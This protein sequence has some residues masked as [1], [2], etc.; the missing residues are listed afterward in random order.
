[1]TFSVL[2]LLAVLYE[3]N[4]YTVVHHLTASFTYGDDKGNGSQAR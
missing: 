3:C 2:S 1:V 4:Y